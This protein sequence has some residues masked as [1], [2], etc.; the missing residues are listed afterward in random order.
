VTTH[1]EENFMEIDI[2]NDVLLAIMEKEA[3]SSVPARTGRIQDH[4]VYNMLA[5]SW[6]VVYMTKQSDPLPPAR[7]IKPTLLTRV[8][9]IGAFFNQDITNAHW[10]KL[11][12]NHP[13]AS[14]V[15]EEIKA[16]LIDGTL[17]QQMDWLDSAGYMSM[18]NKQTG[19][20]T[21]S[22]T[23]HNEFLADTQ[24][25]IRNKRRLDWVNMKDEITN[26]TGGW[27]EHNFKTPRALTWTFSIV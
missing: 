13:A 18:F 11:C 3:A 4:P 25:D 20:F 19:E 1:T 7:E 23:A 6:D 16:S 9:S 17:G 12:A 5:D 15:V 26:P 8:Q 24:K 14:G 21:I 10:N 27:I 2:N 22:F